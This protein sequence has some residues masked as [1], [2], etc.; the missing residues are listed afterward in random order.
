MTKA[1]H[2]LGTFQIW[3]ASSS[4]RARHSHC[5]GEE[6]ESPALH[7]FYMPGTGNLRARSRTSFL[8][9]SS[10]AEYLLRFSSELASLQMSAT[11]LIHFAS[12][13]ISFSPKPL[14]VIAGVP[15]RTPDGRK[16][17][18]SSSGKALALSVRPT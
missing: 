6:F 12:I 2:S 16:A 13:F 14:V 3:G 8:M 1:P 5:R 18:A 7:Q 9:V 10:S 17:A 15:S 11:F 4:G